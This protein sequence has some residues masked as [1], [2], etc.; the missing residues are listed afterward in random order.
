MASTISV[1]MIVKNDVQVIGDA[2]KSAMDQV[3]EIVV[4]D[5]GSI[6]HTVDVTRRLSVK[7]YE[8]LWDNR[9]ASM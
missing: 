2:L 3:D 7:V 6:D 9:F 1:C 8:D 5:T 4:V